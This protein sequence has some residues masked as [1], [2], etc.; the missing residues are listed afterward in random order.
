MSA[1]PRTVL[2]DVYVT[3][4]YPNHPGAAPNQTF[5]R[6][7]TVVDV[8]LGSALE[9]LYGGAGNLSGIIPVAQRGDGTTLSRAA[10]G[11]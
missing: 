11:N 1:N 2:T 10:L 3:N 8:P 7:G 9:A 4:G 6:H 5:T